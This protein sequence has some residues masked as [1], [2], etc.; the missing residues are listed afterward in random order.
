M[1][2]N[3]WSRRT[4]LASTASPWLMPSFA[5]VTDADEVQR[6]PTLDIHAHLFGIG[7]GGTG[8][9]MS[10]S[11]TD[12]PAFRYLMAMLKLRVPGRTVDERYEE[13]LV[14]QT[15]QS[16]LTK[17]AILGQDAVYD[18]R[19]KADWSE[20]LGEFIVRAGLLPIREPSLLGHAEA[21][22]EKDA[23]FGGG[24]GSC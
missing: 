24:G 10:R 23:A 5:N 13:V 20:T 18:N 17:A 8:C 14:Q 16:G 11:I 15:H 22:A 21:Y 7:D 2:R 6:S 12:G 3:L 4:F 19:G 1:M 9:R